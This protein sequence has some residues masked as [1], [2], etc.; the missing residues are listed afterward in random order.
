MV[1]YPEEL[2]WHTNLS[3]KI[4]RK[5]PQL[6]KFHQFLVSETE[7]V[8]RFLW[9]HWFPPHFK[10]A[11]GSWIHLGPP[12]PGGDEVDEAPRPHLGMPLPLEGLGIYMAALLLSSS[13]A[14]MSWGHR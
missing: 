2:A 9:I 1:R 5:S 8:S 13:D 10:G 7:S 11:L 12:G 6:E 14:E 4:L 3:R